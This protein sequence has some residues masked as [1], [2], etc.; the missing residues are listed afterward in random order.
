MKKTILKVNCGAVMLN[1]FLIPSLAVFML[2]LVFTL[3]GIEEDEWIWTIV[4]IILISLPTS[5]LYIN[6][7]YMIQHAELG[8]QGIVIHSLFSTVKSIQW[9]ELIEIR[10]ENIITFNAHGHV[11]SKEWIVLYTNPS[12]KDTKKRPCNRKKT[13]PWYICSTN[14]HIFLLTEYLKRYAPHIHI[15]SSK[16]PMK[17]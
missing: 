17:F 12:Q 8:E 9:N 5:Y 16:W 1:A 11:S 15:S 7:L 10:T 14:T 13:G 2:V 3:F 4:L 6:A